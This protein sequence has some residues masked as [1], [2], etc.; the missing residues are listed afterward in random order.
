MKTIGASTTHDHKQNPQHQTTLLHPTSYPKHII[1]K[2]HPYTTS[3]AIV[4]SDAPERGGEEDSKLYRQN[5]PDV[6]YTPPGTPTVG[7]TRR[8]MERVD[9]EIQAK[10]QTTQ[11]DADTAGEKRKKA[12]DAS[13]ALKRHKLQASFHSTQPGV[14]AKKTEDVVPDN[15]QSI[16]R[17][18]A[19]FQDAVQDAKDSA[20]TLVQ[21]T[22]ESI[23]TAV[24]CL[25]DVIQQMVDDAKTD[26][27]SNVEDMRMQQ[28]QIK[29]ELEKQTTSS[30]NSAIQWWH[31][32]MQL[33]PKLS[34]Q[35]TTT[36]TSS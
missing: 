35:T 33:K 25:K 34:C 24:A 31:L 26:V 27:D 7:S 32:S 18:K 13:Q 20:Q 14:V 9:P 11:D 3:Q 12:Q 30:T 36:T 15:T 4:M 1:Y 28:K 19:D 16:A 23:S 22:E 29:Y 6:V 8:Q 10:L 2:P 5:G 21:A 17:S